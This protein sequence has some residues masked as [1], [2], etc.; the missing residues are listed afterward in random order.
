MSLL[1]TY[2]LNEA[3]EFERSLGA[4]TYAVSFQTDIPLSGETMDEIADTLT[5]YNIS[6]QEVS[7]T[8]TTPNTVT[9]KYT[10][11]DNE[12]VG[13][14][15]A[16][17]LPLIVPL[18][19]IGA[20]IFGIIKIEDISKSLVPLILILGGVGIILGYIFKEPAGEVIKKKYG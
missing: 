2:D 1:E 15:W 16:A 9:I 3:I 19:T 18:A 14:A 17:V 8:G 11:T 7:Q 13:F 4:G 12:G 6:W 20:V 5:G 10:R